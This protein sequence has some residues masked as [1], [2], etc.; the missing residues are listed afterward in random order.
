MKMFGASHIKLSKFYIAIG[1]N[2]KRFAVGFGIDAYSITLDLGPF[3]F[4]IE[5]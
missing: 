5:V 1:F 2:F 3:W 4:S